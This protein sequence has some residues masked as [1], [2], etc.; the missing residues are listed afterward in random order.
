MVN[1]KDERARLVQMLKMLRNLR[2]M[3][4]LRD[5]LYQRE[6]KCHI[7]INGH[8][9]MG[10]HPADGAHSDVRL[11]LYGHLNREIDA[12]TAA[13]EAMEHG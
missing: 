4:E 9:V 6:T 3:E 2:Q 11:M 13:Y 5:A 7:T 12:L 8:A 10:F 1:T